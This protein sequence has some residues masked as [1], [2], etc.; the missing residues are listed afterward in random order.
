MPIR[1]FW[2]QANIMTSG[3]FTTTPW[4]ARSAWCLFFQ[5]K[6]RRFGSTT[7]QRHRETLLSDVV[8]Q[9]KNWWFL[10]SGAIDL[11]WDGEQNIESLKYIEVYWSILKYIE[12]IL[13]YI[14]VYWS[15]LKY[16]EVYWSILKYIEVYIGVNA[17]VSWHCCQATRSTL[18]ASE[19]DTF[20]HFGRQSW[21]ASEGPQ[22]W[23]SWVSLGNSRRGLKQRWVLRDGLH[24]AVWPLKHWYNRT[25]E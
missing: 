23:S 11:A 13:K 14:E 5:T 19:F 6:A 4:G 17:C 22:P 8:C 15:I 16:I 7:L 2:G 24:Q 1:L 21:V 9:M 10:S 18:N 20:W 3:D 12:V 25:G